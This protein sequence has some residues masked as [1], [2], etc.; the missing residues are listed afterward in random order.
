MTI[1]GVQ[2]NCDVLDIITELQSQLHINGIDL[3]NIIKPTTNDILVQCPYHKFGKEHKPSAGIRKS[4]GLFACFTCKEVHSLQE[5]I[6]HCFGHYDDMIGAFGWNWLLRNFASVRV[7]ERKDVR[8][9]IIRP[10]ISDSFT[11][12]N[13]RMVNKSRN[14]PVG[15]GVDNNTTDIPF[16]TEEELDSYRYTHPYW[17]K[18]GIVDEVIIELFDLGYSQEEKM[19]TFPNLDK[20]GNCVFVA[21]RSVKT[22]LFNYPKDA[23]KHIYGIYQLYQLERFPK[24]VYITESMIDCIL[25]W[26]VGKY[27]CAMNGL[28]TNLQYQELTDMPCRQFILATDSDSA[29]MKARERIK[30]NVKGKMFTEVVL[31]QGRKDIGECTREELE[32][33]VEVW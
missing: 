23:V 8:V 20:D 1:N 10:T 16:V 25:L 11:I 31:P 27:A 7:E 17:A 33:L 15:M 3:L 14:K 5:V 26:Q 24:E 4:D 12:Q 13:H 22:K 28:G 9:D 18:R 21:K 30:K 32:N 2:F 6:S 29:G 19:I